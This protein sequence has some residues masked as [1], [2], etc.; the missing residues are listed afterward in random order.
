MSKNGKILTPLIENDCNLLE[1]YK[2]FK[3]YEAAKK[4]LKMSQDEVI[5]EVQKSNLR[6]LGGAGF[7]TGRK[8][9]FIPKNSQKPVYLVINCDES[10]PGTFKDKYIV[11]SATHVLIEGIIIASYAIGA[12]T[13]YIYIRGEYVEPA[14]RIEAAIKEALKKRGGI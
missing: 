3:G 6:G 1:N 8:W 11:S 7:P 2:K 13:C 12:H 10:E 9:A 4:A 5:E 14:R